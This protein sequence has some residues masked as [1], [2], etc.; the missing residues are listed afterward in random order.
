LFKG[1]AARFII[2]QLRCHV[3][4]IILRKTMRLTC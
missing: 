1:S 3:Y 4:T 2:L